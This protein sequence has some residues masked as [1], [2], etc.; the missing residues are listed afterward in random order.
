MQGDEKTA[1]MRTSL[2][3]SP[4]RGSKQAL[5]KTL[6]EAPMNHAWPRQMAGE[7]PQASG[8]SE[9]TASFLPSSHSALNP[10]PLHTY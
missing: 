6:A 3:V 9:C 7:I 2:R 4:A 8:L 10:S 5:D 1:Q